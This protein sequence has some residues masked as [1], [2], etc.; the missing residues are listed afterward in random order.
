MIPEADGYTIGGGQENLTKPNISAVLSGSFTA[1]RDRHEMRHGAA[2]RPQ[3]SARSQHATQ[4]NAARKC[5]TAHAV[6]DANGRAYNH[7]AHLPARREMMQRWADYLDK[8][9]AGADVT[10]LRGAA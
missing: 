3:K 8:L 5:N 4:Q 7:T 6:K 1:T 2:R 9:R 10:P